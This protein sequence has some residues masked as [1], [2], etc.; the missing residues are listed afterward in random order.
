MGVLQ[1]VDSTH[2]AFLHL[3]DRTALWLDPLERAN[4]R[5]CRLR[6]GSDVHH[7]DGT[8]LCLV[9]RAETAFL[10]LH[11]QDRRA[12][13]CGPNQLSKVRGSGRAKPF[14]HVEEAAA[15]N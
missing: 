3:P 4:P 7:R 13:R 2:R 11:T 10:R 8:S 5:W 15:T 14:A 1:A 12:A 6:F 9:Y